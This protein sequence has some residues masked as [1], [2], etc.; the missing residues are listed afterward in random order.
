MISNPPGRT[1]RI[2]IVEDDPLRAGGLVSCL[3]ELGFGV[4]GVISTAV[5]ADAIVSAERPDLALVNI[6]LS[7]PA[8]NPGVVGALEQIHRLP[9]VF[10]IETDD[11]ALRE[12]MGISSPSA[13]VDIPLRPTQVLMAVEEALNRRRALRYAA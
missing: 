2:L 5:E 7:R 13:V 12:R 6:G 9:C 3:E 1:A 8:D 10:M 4:A 11:N